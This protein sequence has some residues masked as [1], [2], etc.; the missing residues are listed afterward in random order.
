MEDAREDGIA[1]L[2]IEDD[3]VIAG[4]LQTGLRYEGYRISTC[5]S[6][7]EGLDLFKNA[8]FD[9]V[10]LDVVLPGMD[11]FDVCRRVRSRGS[12]VPVL[13]LTVKNEV[14]DRVRGLDSGADDYLSKPFDFDELLARVRA[15][16]RRSG[17]LGEGKR[18]EAGCLSLDT[19]TR[20]VEKNGVRITLT[21]TEFALLEL[22]MGH[23]RRVFT[24]EIL[25]NRVFGYEYDGGTNVIDVHI[26]HLRKKLNDSPARLIRTVYGVGY[27][28][29]PDNTE[30]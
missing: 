8:S 27:G 13:M 19:E 12:D 2:V 5:F 7:E 25:L 4:F 23:P 16:L 24:R 30:E 20:E 11:G 3:P 6:G 9:L 10:I 28:F 21:P 14:S 15:L 1:I 29:Y 17:K 22:F 26:N 18:M